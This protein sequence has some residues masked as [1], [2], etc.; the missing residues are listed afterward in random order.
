MSRFFNDIPKNPKY[1]EEITR[2][3]NELVKLS[4]RVKI[5]EDKLEAV[6]DTPRWRNMIIRAYSKHGVVSGFIPEKIN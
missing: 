5:L 2:L 6:N 3:S 4:E 1:E